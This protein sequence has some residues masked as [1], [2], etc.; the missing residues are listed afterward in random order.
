MLPIST[1]MS[2]DNSPRLGRHL[3]RVALAVLCAGTFS[4]SAAQET[5]ATPTV[6]VATSA[7]EAV[8]AT[9][10]AKL[11]RELDI[12]ASQPWTD[13][14]IDLV[15]GD[16]VVVESGGQV[17]YQAQFAGPEGLKRSWM[18]LTR[19]LPVNGAGAASLVGR[20]GEGAAAIPFA[21]GARKDTV[22]RRAG[23]LFLGVNQAANQAGEG[24][25]HA[26]VQV[27]AAGAAVAASV[28]RVT[29]AILQQVPRRIGDQQGNPGDMVNFLII[30]SRD[31]LTKTYMDAGWMLADKGK[32]QAVFHALTA[33]LD[34]EAYL[35]MPMSPLYLFGRVQDFG[36]EH[37]EPVQM[38][39]QRHHLR[40][41]KAPFQIEGHPVW[42]G[43]ATHDIGFEKDRRNNGVTH[44][45]DPAID[46]EREYLGETLD[47]TGEVAGLSHVLPSDPLKEAHT[48][49]GGSF[50]SDGQIL[51]IQLK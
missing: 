10:A 13:T 45:I 20:I 39:A 5:P 8:R 6:P 17:K 33:T 29:P 2:V 34:K 21:L 51:V 47:A 48:A 9:L 4:L 46:K 28:I 16:R 3:R 22:A 49:T 41:W 38:V 27:F 40:I 7:G 18:D 32:K 31:A 19:S 24:S 42:V 26:K 30:G 50:T 36:Y 11:T 23:H 14:G 1:D 15:V 35:A 25:F 43:A 37:A 44:K 12:P